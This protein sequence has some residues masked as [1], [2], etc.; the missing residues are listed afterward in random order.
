MQKPKPTELKGLLYIIYLR[1]V[2]I[3]T[4]L[5]VLCNTSIT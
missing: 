4:K 2:N 3:S 1:T 5:I